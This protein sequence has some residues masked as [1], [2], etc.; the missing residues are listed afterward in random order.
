MLLKRLVI[1]LSIATLF[2]SGCILEDSDRDKSEKEP[3]ML[4]DLS[5]GGGVFIFSN[6]GYGLA[7]IGTFFDLLPYEEATVYVNGVE[8][9][10][11]S[12]LHSNAEQLS[13]DLLTSKN[14]I[15]I[16]VYAFGDSLIEEI[17][18][19]ETPVILKPEEGTT[20]IVGEELLVEI[21]FPGEHRYI[22]MAL[23]NQDNVAVGLESA[24]EKMTVKIPGEMLPNAGTS[25]LSALS[26]QTVN[27]IP[28]NFNPNKDYTLFFV[29][30]VAIR[31]V[32]FA[33]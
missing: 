3:K 24:E 9:E 23:T 30:T 31:T 28:K 12:G 32:E 33:L 10:N 19:P 8:M 20:A 14:T 26:V 15:R 17:P 22:S 2:L 6:E 13:I 11:K 7:Q 5:M 16:A 27:E 25:M 21:D 4:K 29:T 18:V 1:I